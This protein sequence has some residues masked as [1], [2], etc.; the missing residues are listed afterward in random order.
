MKRALILL[1]LMLSASLP[2]RSAQVRGYWVLAKEMVFSEITSTTTPGVPQIALRSSGPGQAT[3]SSR[4]TAYENMNSRTVTPEFEVEW[5]LNRPT[6]LYPD[7]KEKLFTTY[8]ILKDGQTFE[9]PFT[10]SSQDGSTYPASLIHKAYIQAEVTL[11]ASYL[12]GMTLSGQPFTADDFIK[13]IEERSESMSSLS[14]VM[15]SLDDEDF[16]FEDGEDASLSSKGAL[17]GTLNLKDK[18]KDLPPSY[19]CG[20]DA[21]LLVGVDA[22]IESEGGYIAMNRPNNNACSATVHHLLVYKFVSSDNIS[23]TQDALD[24]AGEDDGTD[25]PWWIVVGAGGAGVIGASRL[26]KKGGKKKGTLKETKS[27]K[28]PEEQKEKE[29]DEEQKEAPSKYK[30]ILAKEFGSTLKV[31]EGPSRVGVRIEEITARGQRIKRGDLTERIQVLGKENISIKDCFYKGDYLF[32]D[33]Q[34]DPPEGVKSGK[35]IVTF[36]F[37]GLGGHLQNNVIFNIVNDVQEIIFQQ[38]N[39]TF[40]AGRKSEYNMA[41][42]VMGFS[43]DEKNLSFSSEITPS[44][45]HGFVLS[46]IR[47]DEGGM[48]CLDIKDTMEA[49]EAEPGRLEDYVCKV[50][51]RKLDQKSGRERTLEGSFHICRFHEGLRL[52]VGH[53]RAYPVV[54]GTGGV[55]DQEVLP[56]TYQEEM[57]VPRTGV[58]VTLFAY[59]E[60]K[61][62]LCTPAPGEVRFKIEDVPDSVQFFGKKGEEIKEPCKMLGFDFDTKNATVSGNMNTLFVDFGPAVCLSAPTRAKAKVTCTVTFN[63]QD[64]SASRTVMVYSQPKRKSDISRLTEYGKTDEKI[65]D[66]ILHM[67]AV[68]LEKDSAA[69]MRPL[70]HKLGLLL[71]SYDPDFGYFMPEYQ[72]LRN[73]FM[74]F[75]TGEIGPFYVNEHVYNE[76]EVNWGDAFDAT[77]EDCSEVFPDSFLGRL[78]VDFITMGAAEY[79]YYT[80]RDFL[81]ECRKVAGED[82]DHG[83]WSNFAVGAVY[84]ARECLYSCAFQK[85]TKKAFDTQVGKALQEEYKMFAVGASDVAKELTGRYSKFAT[86]YRAAQA[87]RKVAGM[88]IQFKSKAKASLE[89]GKKILDSSPELQHLK[90]A[91]ELAKM[92]G[93]AKAE[94]F[95]EKCKRADCTDK[96]L[97]EAMLEVDTDRYAKSYMNNTKAVA[98]KYRW[99]LK[100]E[101]DMAI[102]HTELKVKRIMA[103]KYHCSESEV[104]FFKATGNEAKSAVS[105]KKI[106]MDHDYTIRV[107]GKDLPEKEASRVWNDTYYETVKGVKAASEAEADVLGHALEHT[108][109]NKYGLES[110]GDDVKIILS[111][112]AAHTKY[113]NAQKVSDTQIYK[114]QEHLR[115]GEDLMKKA[116][117]SKDPE[118]AEEYIK[119]AIA[120]YK[121]GARQFPKG[122]SRTVDTKL[123]AVIA[124][125]KEKGLNMRMVEEAMHNRNIIEEALERDMAGDGS[126]IIELMAYF[127]SSSHTLSDAADKAFSIIPALNNFL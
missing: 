46:D 88:K 69:Q 3:F 57:E 77:L 39:F 19:Q 115:E 13:L 95:I 30:M 97:L 118:R 4:Y 11:N 87:V 72:Y 90:K 60:K 70:I 125:G 24:E 26:L 116:M 1:F 73:M 21:I 56:Q 106:G 78:T 66:D 81:V 117:E 22:T 15:E 36:T 75:I 84:G 91:N 102:G 51:A 65:T 9:N 12:G 31:G 89:I 63:H 110:F 29:N 108:A 42:R 16:E 32:A 33:I 49:G 101:R 94:R 44:H 83:F 103:E 122:M 119:K 58:W 93:K 35:G 23:I 80:P 104:T 114:I 96:E 71:D 92:E 40:I 127:E 54:R 17:R 124:R 48:W 27:R 43:G 34:A 86:A 45:D 85:L 68:L 126:A 123:E 64:Y 8:Q 79:V 82:R 107:R 28:K 41:F 74:R 55:K 113:M 53:I 25:I 38:D 14:D 120:C 52:K 37:T 6:E 2:A 61:N 100:M 20:E 109:V 10:W 7:E 121:E 5:K 18:E 62:E 99:R 112:D 59:D 76:T 47:T 111:K 105:C 98:D 50:K 67:R